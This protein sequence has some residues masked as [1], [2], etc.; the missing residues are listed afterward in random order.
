MDRLLDELGG[1]VAAG[2]PGM[3]DAWLDA[4]PPA[5]RDVLA[6]AVGTSGVPHPPQERRSDRD[7]VDRQTVLR[8]RAVLALVPTG[9]AAA[10]R[11]TWDAA[12]ID[13]VVLLSTIAAR[14]PAWAEEFVLTALTTERR[15]AWQRRGVAVLCL[16]L[17]VHL[18]IDPPVTPAP[19]PGV[20][21][22]LR[23]V[24]GKVG[25]HLHLPRGAAAADPALVRGGRCRRGPGLPRRGM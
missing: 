16:P 4:L 15:F 5:E 11:M 24:G 13:P 22:V 7:L 1:I 21:R 25:R 6:T 19:G 12:E 20:E 10:D 2:D 8:A 14:G 23:H 9:G 3:F 17:I 18:G